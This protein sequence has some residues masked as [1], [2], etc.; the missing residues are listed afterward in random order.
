MTPIH[1]M[2]ILKSKKGNFST[3]KFVLGL[4]TIDLI[5]THNIMRFS[6]FFFCFSKWHINCFGLFNTKTNFE[7]G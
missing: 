7:E 1:F 5:I 2:K 3:N 4:W 6:L